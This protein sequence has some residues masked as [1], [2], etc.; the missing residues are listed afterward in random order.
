MGVT[1]L[2]TFVVT[3]CPDGC[4]VINLKDVAENHCRTYPGSVPV[5]IVDAMSCLRHWY[6]PESWVCGGQ[7][8]E[9]RSNLDSFINRF[10]TAGIK[11]VFCFDGLVEQKK[12]SKWVQRRLRNN[13]EIAKIFEFIKANK[14]Q[15]GRGMFFIPSGLATFTRFALKTL[16][17]ETICSMQ[18]A[19]YEIATYAQKN[20]CM[21]ILG[22]DTDYLIYD[23][24]PYFSISKLHLDSLETVMYSR[25]N[26]C[27]WL[28]LSVPDLPLLACLLGTD[29][30][31]ERAMEGFRNQCLSLYR[32]KRQSCDKKADTIIAVANYIS[33]I[34]HVSESL[35]DL[36]KM[37]PLRSDKSI[38]R[39]GIES[40]LL[41]EQHS[42]WLPCDFTST[43]QLAAEQKKDFPICLDQEIFQIAKE[44]H[45]RAENHMIYNI[46][47][48][49][50]IDCSN[51]LEDEYDT[52]LPGQAL[53]YRPARQ[54]IYS[55]LL[56][57]AKDASGAYPVVKEWFV[58]AGNSLQQPDLMQP[59]Q[60]PGG[61][62]NLRT[63]W[64][65]RS[66]EAK[67]Q[68]LWTFLACFQLQD[69]AEDLRALETPFFVVCS[70]LLYLVLQ[71][72][73]LSL[74]DLHAFMAQALC[75]QEKSAAQLADLQLAQIDSRAVQLGSLFV[76]GLGVLVM[77]NSACGFPFQMDDLMPWHVFD[78]KLFQEKYHQAHRGCP[79]N[80]LLEHN[81]L[82]CTKFQNLLD[83]I[84]KASVANGRK[85][86]SRPRP[87]SFTIG[88][89]G[90]GRGSHRRLLSRHPSHS[91]QPQ[92][93][94][95][96]WREP[97]PTGSFSEFQP[98]G[99]QYRPRHQSLRGQFQFAPRWPR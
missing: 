58:Y 44:Q 39:K 28:G 92:C 11:L 13:K 9:Y 45:I 50:E 67:K 97:Q 75:L 71:V 18:E 88:K 43:L 37:L 42:P 85:I 41:P 56:E 76:R 53:I 27:H 98:S 35:M 15:P 12:R 78:G 93:R 72:D 59:K 23:T 14:Q 17:Q 4:L 55:I 36:E 38:L 54:H 7:W 19:D 2:Y 91:Y 81:E 30:V 6:T 63:L 99:S 3:A 89:H 29:T 48:R 57:S 62:P 33:T 10:T 20:N 46:L 74:E 68:R 24:V 82:R 87:S 64:L 80:Q 16:G 73:S 49:A 40:Y 90:R 60:L 5:L 21:G 31:P 84:C 52:S 65:N 70:L 34:P 22:E 47:S 83:L 32:A 96:Q 86:Q 1:G 25:Q 61:N 26:L 77:A 69:S 94:E 51:T 95:S 8:R 79:L 66:A